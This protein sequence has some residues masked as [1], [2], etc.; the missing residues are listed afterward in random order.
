[1]FVDTHPVT[2]GGAVGAT[3]GR[4]WSGVLGIV[5]VNG[6]VTVVID[7]A[8]DWF[9]ETVAVCAGWAPAETEH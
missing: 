2:L 8:L 1:M 7:T 4:G 5:T 9:A 3:K 6:D